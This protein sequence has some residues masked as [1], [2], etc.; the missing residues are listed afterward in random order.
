[1]NGRTP[2]WAQN[3]NSIRSS[4]KTR[5]GE[6]RPGGGEADGIVGGRAGIEMDQ[7]QALHAGLLWP[8]RGPA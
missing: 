7:H 6:D 2:K 4:P 3:S 1:M 5:V 8:L